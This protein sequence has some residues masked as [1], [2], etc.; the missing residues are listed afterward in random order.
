[1]SEEFAE[2]DKQ[3]ARR[4]AR[5]WLATQDI[6]TFEVAPGDFDTYGPYRDA[7]IEAV[8]EAWLATPLGR[9]FRAHYNSATNRAAIQNAVGSLGLAISLASLDGIFTSLRDSGKLQRVL[10]PQERVELAAAQGRAAYARKVKN[11][12]RVLRE[13][14]TDEI[15][16]LVRADKEFSEWLREKNLDDTAPP[17][18]LPGDRELAARIAEASGTPKQPRDPSGMDPELIQFAEEYRRTPSREIKTKM[19]DATF[20]AKVERAA[21]AGLL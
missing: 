18:E 7:L 20:V 6:A 3:Q 21:A 9:E 16:A 1:M 19:H 2:Q 14:T 13:K 4:D 15:K 11:W 8:T 17:A 10:T 12:N 5:E